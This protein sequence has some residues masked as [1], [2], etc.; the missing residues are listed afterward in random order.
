LLTME[1]SRGFLLLIGISCV[2]LVRQTHAVC[3]RTTGFV[4]F[5]MKTGNCGNVEG[6]GWSSLRDCAT[7]ICADGSALNGRYCGRGSCNMFGCNC[8]GGC[9]TGD[10][11]KSFEKKHEGY[12][13]SII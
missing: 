6:A 10:W 4:T 11:E 5:T 13:I 7:H 3:C 1:L 8:D 2:I 9:R 12:G